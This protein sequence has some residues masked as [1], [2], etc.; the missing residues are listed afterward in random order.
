VWS[1]L[2]EGKCAPGGREAYAPDGPGHGSRLHEI[3]GV[4]LAD[5]LCCAEFIKERK[6]QPAPW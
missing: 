3:K 2:L 6:T 1:P 4:S 5:F